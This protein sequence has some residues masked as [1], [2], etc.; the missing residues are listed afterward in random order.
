MSEDK[1]SLKYYFSKSNK[2]TP[3]Y[4]LKKMGNLNT[5][6]TTIKRAMKLEQTAV[7]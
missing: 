1:P 2:A 5:K 7:S 6:K 3:K 4:S